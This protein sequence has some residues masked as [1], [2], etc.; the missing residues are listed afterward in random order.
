MYT[1][2]TS[3][4]PV[5][6]SRGFKYIMVAYDHDSNKIHA[7]PKKNCSGP[8]LL[9]SYTE[10]HNLLS[11]RGLAP[12]MNYLDNE[13]QTVLQKFMTAKDKR[14]QLVPPHLHR[15]N[16][17]E[18]AIQTFKNHFI[19]G[20]ASVSKISPSIFGAGCYRTAYSP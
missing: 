16:P 3:Q 17:A 19:A 11:E 6:S 12:K 8:E 10:I 5:R 18:R 7:K 2:K 13:C 14:F 9:K 20:I 15:R 4:F 1:D